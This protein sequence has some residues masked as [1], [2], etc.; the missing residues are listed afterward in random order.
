MAGLAH[1]RRR[2]LFAAGLLLAGAAGLR[3]YQID[4][5]PLHADEA[6][7]AYQTWQLLRG[8]GYTY[9]PADKHGPL[10]YY[11]AAAIA[12][13]SGWAPD[14]LSAPR[15][16][17]VPLLAGLG[18]LVLLLGAAPRLG[19][20]PVLIGAALLAAAPLAV[21]YDTYFVQEAWFCF[22]TWALFFATLRFLE[23]APPAECAGA[24]RAQA[25]SPIR[26]PGVPAALLVGSL[27]GLMQT[28]KE[29][30]VL[31]FAALGVA[32][33]AVRMLRSSGDAVGGTRAPAGFHLL[34]AGLTAAAIY[35][36]FYSAFFTRWTGLT[37]G[38]R[39]YFIY[40][41]RAAGSAHDQPWSYYLAL[42]WPHSRG[43]VSWGEPLLL[44]A[45]LGGVIAAFSARASATHRALA[46]FTL[47]LL[48]LYSVIPYKM[49][50][51]LLTPYIGL[52]MLAGLGAVQLG[53]WVPGT[54]GRYAPGLVGLAL[55]FGGAWR[56]G[57]AL[58][59]YAN[60]SRNPY[61]YQPTSADVRRLVATV[62]ALPVGEKI[63][64]VS[65]DHAWPLP[66][67]LRD[68]VATGYFTTTPANL[69][70]YD[71]VLF[72][73]RLPAGPPVAATAFGLRPDILLWFAPE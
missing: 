10:L 2:F 39:T 62:A 27:A 25:R 34:V 64:V 56:A 21:I 68:R 16:R 63:A 11:G 52:A 23:K 72:D 41:A 33:L 14:A 48:L 61:V 53:H 3:L 46:I 24:S 60:D 35:L 40:A 69:A 5:R 43:G 47:T 54:V 37:D 50:W 8:D 17:S 49:P 59:R 4:R 70:A 13:I 67:Y 55:V 71:L 32:L 45:S 65:P 26:N 31:H 57:P 73:S 29:T 66:W 12:K 19:R 38:L 42:L 18:T 15:L 36:V 20:T 9:D 44:L 51:L 1:S 7:Q 28:T 22:L 6:V 58:G 30:S